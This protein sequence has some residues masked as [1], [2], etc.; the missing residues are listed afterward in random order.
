MFQNEMIVLKNRLRA[1]SGLAM[2][3]SYPPRLGMLLGITPGNTTI[4]A[5]MQKAEIGIRLGVDT[6]T[7]LTLSLD[8][9]L[10]SLLLERLPVPVGSVPV[11]EVF[12]AFRRQPGIDL[13]SLVLHTLEKHAQQGVDF[14]SVHMSVV[15][16]FL[17]RL[18]ASR[19]TILIASRGGAMVASLMKETGQENPFF[20]L[21]DEI[22]DLCKE[23]HVTLSI[24]GT[25][26][27][28]SVTDAFD[29][30]HLS[31]MELQHGIVERAHAK[32]VQT[33]VELINHVPLS[34]IERYVELGK[35]LFDGSPLGCLGPS[36]TDIAIA[37]DDVAGA[38][39]AAVA[40]WYGASWLNC[41]TAGEHTYLP[42]DI[43][44]EQAI[45]YFKIALHIGAVARGEAGE[46]DHALSL[47]RAKHDWDTM[48]RLS[49]FEDVA[50]RLIAEH[51]HRTGEPCSICGDACPLMRTRK[52][53]SEPNR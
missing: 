2:G 51:A 21:Q 45:R 28:G 52:L 20:E 18:E 17:S 31:E 1:F 33:I 37:F 34:G 7:D 35:Q 50:H 39:G 47:A 43:E 8:S 26:R 3:N 27:P 16:D 15:R 38:I 49:L 44:I 30:L 12:T 5:E 46:R 36:P 4:E 25:F 11:Y 6:V 48:A 53:I 29:N 9:P 23:Y 22:I 42:R 13:R 19:R 10:R 41:V 40:V 24:V 32:S 14:F